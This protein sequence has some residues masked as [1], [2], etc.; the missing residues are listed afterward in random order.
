MDDKISYNLEQINNLNNNFR[1]DIE[2]GIEE[3]IDY[4]KQGKTPKEKLQIFIMCYVNNPSYGEL[5]NWELTDLMDYIKETDEF[6]EN[7]KHIYASIIEEV[8]FN[9]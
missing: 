2:V 8:N 6:Y 3:F 7:Y 1:Y 9:E 5:A 4:V